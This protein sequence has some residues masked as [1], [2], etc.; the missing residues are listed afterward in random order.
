[1]DGRSRRTNFSHD[2]DDAVPLCN[3]S[4]YHRYP[5]RLHRESCCLREGE[6]GGLPLA[7]AYTL[8]FRQRLI[9]GRYSGVFRRRCET[10]T[11]Q[12]HQPLCPGDAAKHPERSEQV[13]VSLDSV[14][15]AIATLQCF[16]RKGSMAPTRGRNATPPELYLSG[17]SVAVGHPS[18]LAAYPV[19]CSPGEFEQAILHRYGPAQVGFDRNRSLLVW[20]GRTV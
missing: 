3:G 17:P 10:F 7:T 12:H 19:S 15:G 16:S 8:P 9:G 5:Y 6:A 14:K 2:S 4:P 13:T 18:T 1:L 20:V 11:G